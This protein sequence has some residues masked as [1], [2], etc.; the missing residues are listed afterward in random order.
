MTKLKDEPR[1]F[2]VG[3]PPYP[4]LELYVEF[5]AQ[6]RIADASV[7]AFSK[8]CTI[9]FVCGGPSEQPTPTV[10]GEALRGH[11]QRFRRDKLGWLGSH[12][13]AGVEAMITRE[14]ELIEKGSAGLYLHNQ[15]RPLERP[16]YAGGPSDTDMQFY[17]QF[18]WLGRRRPAA[19]EQHQ[20]SDD[21]HMVAD[22]EALAAGECP[23]TVQ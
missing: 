9:A 10:V 4:A 1:R 18:S 17:R 11:I 19:W 21:G 13:R 14:V 23:S 22:K 20:R 6:R 12:T 3:R 15:T 2:K 16:L 7:N 5:E 8:V